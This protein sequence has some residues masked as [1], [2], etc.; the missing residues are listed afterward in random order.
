MRKSLAVVL[1]L[2]MGAL[3]GLALDSQARGLTGTPRVIDP[4]VT[5]MEINENATLR[6]PRKRI[7]LFDVTTRITVKNT[8]EKTLYAPFTSIVN[9]NGAGCGDKKW[10]QSSPTVVSSDLSADQG[11]EKLAPGESATFSIQLEKRP[12][13]RLTYEIVMYGVVADGDPGT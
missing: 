10:T 3:S 9:V 4:F 1:A 11:L 12:N 8:S 5:V 7:T 6:L 2:L 13:T